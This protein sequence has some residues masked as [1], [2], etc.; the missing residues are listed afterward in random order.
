LLTTAFVN[1]D[2]RLAVV[3]MNGG[4]APLRYRLHIGPD[5]AWIS[6]PARAIQTITG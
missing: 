1:P 4:D 2:G 3:V 5:E 6:I